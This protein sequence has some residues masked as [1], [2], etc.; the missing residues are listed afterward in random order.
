MTAGLL[1]AQINNSQLQLL[2]LTS[3]KGA[4]SHGASLR[5][6]KINF[7][8]FEYLDSPFDT[9]SMKVRTSSLIPKTIK[10]RLRNSYFTSKELGYNP[11]LL[12]LSSNSVLIGYFQSYKYLELLESLLGRALC[13]KPQLMTIKYVN[14]LKEIYDSNPIAIHI[15]RGDY[16]GNKTTGLLS[17]EYYRNGLEIINYARRPVWVFS[18]DIN[19][20][21]QKLEGLIGAKWQFA[22]LNKFEN[23]P[24]VFYAMSQFSDLVIAN[25]TFSWWA[26]TLNK[27]K[28]VVTPSKWFL[29]GDDPEYILPPDWIKITPN[30]ENQ[31]I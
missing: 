12:N 14:L 4:Y 25:S 22:D 21:R 18:D 19:L 28:T 9:N 27:K 6:F 30:W 24:E 17:K 11:N 3:T 8:K 13:I 20:A 15:R 7:D 1:H 2:M 29:N 10:S 16:V 31:Q 23:V 26:A 5:D